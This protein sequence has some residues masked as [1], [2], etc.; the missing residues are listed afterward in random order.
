[1][2]QPPFPLVAAACA[3]SQFFKQS[4]SA[5]VDCHRQPVSKSQLSN[6]LDLSALA[7]LYL[8]RLVA[9]QFP[10][11]FIALRSHY[12]DRL[13]EYGRALLY[14]GSD[15]ELSVNVPLRHVVRDQVADM[16]AT[17]ILSVQDP[18]VFT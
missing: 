8:R 7:A 4:A 10:A 16:P 14:P 5:V 15:T 18:P 1:M 3:S 6:K 9:R 12:H 11:A 17:P 13:T 2:V